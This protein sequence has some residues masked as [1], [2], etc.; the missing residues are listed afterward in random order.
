LEVEPK[1]AVLQHLPPHDAGH[2]VIS[3]AYTCTGLNQ[4][5]LN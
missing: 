5:G 2:R 3:R 1:L 4:G